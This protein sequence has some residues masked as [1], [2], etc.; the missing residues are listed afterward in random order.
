MDEGISKA[1]ALKRASI[2]NK[3]VSMSESDRKKFEAFRKKSIELTFEDTWAAWEQE[4]KG[5]K[6]KPEHKEIK[7]WIN[8]AFE[9][10]ARQAREESQKREDSPERKAQLKAIQENALKEKRAREKREAKKLTTLKK[11]YFEP[12]K[13]K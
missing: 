11:S 8:S 10:Q 12:K 5:V 13:G 7:T 1:Q 4:Q 9:E 6:Y 2:Y 3:M